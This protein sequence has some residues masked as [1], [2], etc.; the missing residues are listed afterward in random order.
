MIRGLFKSRSRLSP[1]EPSVPMPRAAPEPQG[2]WRIIVD[3]E[4]LPVTNRPPQAGDMLARPPVAYNFKG[5]IPY[6]EPDARRNKIEN[7]A[8]RVDHDLKAHAN[9]TLLDRAVFLLSQDDDG[10]RLLSRARDNNFS[11]V[12]DVRTLDE[13]EANGLM[14][15][16]NKLIPVRPSSSVTDL[17]LTLKHELEHMDQFATQNVIPSPGATL[18]DNLRATRAIEAGARVSEAITAVGLMTGSPRGPVQQ[19]KS[20]IFFRTLGQ[21]IPELGTRMVEAL[22]SAHNGQ[23]HDFA[24]RIFPSFYESERLM[25]YYDRHIIDDLISRDPRD[26]RNKQLLHNPG[27]SAAEIKDRLTVRG[28]VQ[29]LQGRSE[30]DLDSDKYAG[31]SPKSSGL[32]EKL[33][34]HIKKTA[35]ID[36]EKLIGSMRPSP[37]EEKTPQA[38]NERGWLKKWFG[39]E[40]KAE[41][42]QQKSVTAIAP[43]PPAV[44]VTLNPV[45]MP[46]RIDGGM[47]SDGQ[48]S[49]A[50]TTQRFMSEMERNRS[51]PIHDMLKINYAVDRHVREGGAVHDLLRCGLRAPIGAFPIDYIRHLGARLQAS[52]AQAYKL[53]EWGNLAAEEKEL[54]SHWQKLAKEGH[55]PVW[56]KA[57]PQGEIIDTT[58]QT[59]ARAIMRMTGIEQPTT[60]T[61]V[62]G[63][64]KPGQ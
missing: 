37:P 62:S 35:N 11:I 27:V 14:D 8:D 53:G 2:E 39:K 6:F 10:R 63:L 31:L 57:P 18:K 41:E 36:P 38:S 61:N 50:S 29:Y 9:Q 43:P 20:D 19:F 54:I 3:Q 4:G 59:Y 24:A 42:P 22:P 52:G 15:Y 47:L 25:E 26:I 55:D 5:T 30:I 48:R 7:I 33:Y 28:S 34:H 58:L 44:K 64:K 13:H 60:A 51:L 56:L 49:N 23:W 17:V 21:E 40:T 12:F 16:Q 46:D 1:S 45:I 32:Y